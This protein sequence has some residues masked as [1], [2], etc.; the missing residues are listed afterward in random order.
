MDKLAAKSGGCMVERPPAKT[1]RYSMD[2]PFA[3]CGY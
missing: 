3:K 2:K 1:D